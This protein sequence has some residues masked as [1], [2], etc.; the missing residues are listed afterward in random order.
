MRGW[1]IPLGRWVGVELRVHIF[2]PV[3]AL[4]PIAE[5]LAMVAGQ[6][7]TAAAG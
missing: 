3:L 6:T 5:H 4:G 7:F 1:S 2:F